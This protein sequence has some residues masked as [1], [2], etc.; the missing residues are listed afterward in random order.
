M[1]NDFGGSLRSINVQSSKCSETIEE[2]KKEELRKVV[3][4]KAGDRQG[5]F[6]EKPKSI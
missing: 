2:S 4:S 6:A 1:T 3:L 5:S